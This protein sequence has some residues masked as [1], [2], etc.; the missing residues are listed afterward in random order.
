MSKSAMQLSNDQYVGWSVFQAA[1]QHR[2]SA[3]D[4]FPVMTIS[5]EPGADPEGII[6]AL[7]EKTGFVV[8]DRRILHDVAQKTGGNEAALSN[9][10]ERRRT[11]LADA[12]HSMII[13][14]ESTNS[15]F[16]INLIRTVRAI[17]REGRAIIVGRGAN[18]ICEPGRT[19]RL[20]IVRPLDLRAR[21][22]A[23]MEGLSVEQ[24]LL[25]LRELDNARAEFVQKSFHY[26]PAESR[27]YD[28]VMNSASWNPLQAVELIGQAYLARTGLTA[29]QSRHRS[30]VL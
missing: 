22:L 8:W 13:G 12:V 1:Q 23:R 5:R 11:A 30:A 19:L 9:L 7:A 21:E 20:L 18:F 16:L 25:K 4:F 15:S 17:E 29:D 24:A 6:D 10:D 27:H 2:P 14:H 28:L 3:P 26:N